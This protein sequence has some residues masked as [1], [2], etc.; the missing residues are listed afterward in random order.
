MLLIIGEKE[1]NALP[2]HRSCAS[3][4]QYFQARFKTD[5]SGNRVTFSNFSNAYYDDVFNKSLGYVV[6]ASCNGGY[7]T[8]NS[9]QGT[10]VC[11]GNIFYGD[12]RV[13]KTLG[14]WSPGM[15]FSYNN[16]RWR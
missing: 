9:P 1:A 11:E 4:E 5:R 2:F 12:P 3:M 7:I 10:K 15:S 14:L 13:Q 8:I 16:C 6:T